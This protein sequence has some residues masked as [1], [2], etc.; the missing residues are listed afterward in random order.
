MQCFR[1]CALAFLVAFTLVIA[2]AFGLAWTASDFLPA[3][4]TPAPADAIVVLGHD[5]TRVLEA[6]DRFHEGLAPRVVLARPR[7]STHLALLEPEGVPYPWF[8]VAGRTILTRRGIPE[9]AV[10][11]MPDEVVS[12][13][14]EA[15]AFGRMLP[16]ARRIIVVT[17]PYHVM[18]ARLIFRNELPDRDIRVV[19][20]RYEAMPR[21]WWREQQLAI[22]VLMEFLKLP[23]YLAGGRL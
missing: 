11:V 22:N 7:R 17:S 9:T 3:S 20:S 6:A 19:A 15:I 21:R 18:R 14:T 2:L 13:A 23:F 1:R 10:S 16:E 12:T 5:P 4:D 8:E